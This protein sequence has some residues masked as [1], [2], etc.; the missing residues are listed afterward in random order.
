MLSAALSAVLLLTGCGSTEPPAETVQVTPAPTLEPVQRAFALP[1]SPDGGFHPI[2]GTNRLNLTFAPL[3]YEGLFALDRQ[4]RPEKKLCSGYTVSMDGLQW[5]F[6]LGEARFSDGSPLTAAEAAASLELAR[7]SQHYGPRLADVTK[8][9]AGEGEVILTLS[10]P[11]GALPTLLDM[12]IVK[13]TADPARPLGTGPY[14]LT[15]EDVRQL[16]LNAREAAGVPAKH[17]PLQAVGSGDDLVCA[18]DAREIS[19]VDADLTGT[20]SPGYSARTE[21]TDYP[22][23]TMLYLGFNTVSGLCREEGLRLAVSQAVD[24]QNIAGKL[25]A[26]HAQPAAL[27]LH[28]SLTSYDQ[29]LADALAAGPEA[30]QAT[31]TNAG[32]ALGEDGRRYRKYNV[33]SLKLAVNLENTYKA[34]VADAVAADLTAAGITVHVVKLPWEEFS[35]ALERQSFD[36]YLGETAMTADFD[37]ESLVGP[38]GLLNF[39]GWTDGMLTTL[40]E[41]RRTAFGPARPGAEK[42]VLKRL[43]QTVPIAPLCFKNGSL[44]TQWGQV[45]G[46]QPAQNNVFAKLENWAIQNN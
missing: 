39:G 26:G 3:V 11:N 12:P 40:L 35:T 33:L 32:W 1:C 41:T 15:G 24:R 17:I 46:A 34:A 19:L 44:L 29:E 4:F 28:P 13:E 7:T 2:T 42:A 45:K 43:A 21:T 8:V 38:Q 16:S 27:P 20:D 23:T 10:R 25:M 22:T 37:P 14:V 18:F 30:A 5:R 6:S 9:E 31:L 36:L